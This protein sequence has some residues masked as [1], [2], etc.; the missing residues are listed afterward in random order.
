MS[1]WHPQ[2]KVFLFESVLS[3]KYLSGIQS[4]IWLPTTNSLR[5]SL[6]IH[7]SPSMSHHIG[8]V[9]CFHP[10]FFLS[11]VG[12]ET[13]LWMHTLLGSLCRYWFSFDQRPWPMMTQYLGSNGFVV[14]CSRLV[15]LTSEPLD[16]H[17]RM[18]AHPFLSVFFFCCASVN[19]FCLIWWQVYQSR[20]VPASV[21]TRTGAHQSLAF[22]L[23]ESLDCAGE[24][25]WKKNVM[26]RLFYHKKDFV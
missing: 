5:H 14:F 18:W 12:T 4:K 6:Q 26:D 9:Y 8:G 2:Y 1:M 23:W 22:K 17:R 24:I 11:L 15:G 21:L 19:R 7:G 10:Q 13:Q 20:M 16:Y 3:G 25:K